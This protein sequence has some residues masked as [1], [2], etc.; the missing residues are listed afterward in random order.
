MN[1]NY[2]YQDE[3]YGGYGNA[4]S[5]DYDE[6][7]EESNSVP[8]DGFMENANDMIFEQYRQ[9]TDAVNSLLGKT[10]KLMEVYR[11]DS[12]QIREDIQR[13]FNDAVTRQQQE[14][15]AWLQEELKQKLDNASSK[16]I[17]N[18]ETLHESMKNQIVRFNQ[19]LSE[20]NTKNKRL[21]FQICTCAVMCL[22]L[23]FGGGAWLSY[24]YASVIKK[25]QLDAELLTVI[26]ES[27]LFRCGDRLCART[28]K[29]KHNGFSIIRK[30]KQ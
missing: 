11:L 19:Y 17:Q 16:Y 12:M 20:T 14:T 30:R 13:Q 25:N 15:A 1:N 2:D 27:D 29:N 24:H 5:Q 28:E 18:M 9:A 6:Y 4:D 10:A 26:N 7:D 23:L 21:L 3:E 8:Y 22:T